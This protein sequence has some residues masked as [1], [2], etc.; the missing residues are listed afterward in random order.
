MARPRYPILLKFSTCE[1]QQCLDLYSSHLNFLS[2]WPSSAMPESSKVAVVCSEL[3]A[4]RVCNFG[5]VCER[6]MNT[7]GSY[8]CPR[9]I[10]NIANAPNFIFP[11]IAR[12]KCQYAPHGTPCDSR[13]SLI[14]GR[15]HEEG[16]FVACRCVHC[17]MITINK[18]E[19]K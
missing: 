14:S 15:S 6:E 2:L 8:I 4:I 5:I 18:Y 1:F 7:M 12:A 17:Y 11:G 16:V 19:L 10:F 3:N 13:C 9:S